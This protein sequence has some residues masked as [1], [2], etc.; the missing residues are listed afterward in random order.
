[1]QYYNQFSHLPSSV[2]SKS[3]V[4]FIQ[5]W[6]LTHYQILKVVLYISLLSLGAKAP[7][8]RY[9][10]LVTALMKLSFSSLFCQPLADDE[11][12]TR[13]RHFS[14]SLVR[15]TASAYAMLSSISL[16]SS[17]I[18]SIHFFGGLFLFLLPLI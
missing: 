11:V 18:L 16:T 12:A 2:C 4:H 8:P 5:S 9:S 14:L 6:F 7:P 3:I 15:F 13:L 10:E 1:M 17:F